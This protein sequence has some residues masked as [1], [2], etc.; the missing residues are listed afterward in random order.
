[1]DYFNRFWS[2]RL[3]FNAGLGIFLTL[4]FGIPRFV[5][6][7]GASSGGGYS[8]ISI[9]FLA[10][11]VMPFLLMNKTGRSLIGLHKAKISKWYAISLLLGMVTCLLI[12]VTGFNLYGKTL[13]NWFVYI[14]GS[15]GNS[16]PIAIETHRF[17]VFLIYAII[18][19]TFSPI[20]EELLYRGLI[21]QC[22]V[23]SLGENKASM[24]D[25]AAF[26]LTHLA[27]FGILYTAGGWEFRF[28]PALLWVVL[29]Y[30]T[31]RLFFYCKTRGG[32]LYM[33]ILCHAGFNLA[34]NYLICY[35]L[36]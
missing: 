28:V 8:T 36:L 31:S 1:M 19:M 27:H 21:H 26:A 12:Y 14:A 7:L 22:F 5:L 3:T 30:M 32:S 33:A 10:M 9:L 6:V 2:G 15:Y 18:G 17:Q 16:V 25:S 29:M 11:W 4:L 20:G 35:F 24:A 34:M 23:P 13:N